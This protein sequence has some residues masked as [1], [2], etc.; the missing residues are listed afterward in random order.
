MYIKM[1]HIKEILKA[2]IFLQKEGTNR[3]KTFCQRKQPGRLNATNEAKL[4]K[5]MKDGKL[6]SN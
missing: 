2:A 1:V 5:A 3:Q 6:F 4:Q